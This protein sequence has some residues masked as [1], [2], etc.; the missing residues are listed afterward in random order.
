MA[1]QRRGIA[2]PTD[3]FGAI[4]SLVFWGG[5]LAAGGYGVFWIIGSINQKA[6]SEMVK[7]APRA[8]EANR[9]EASAANRK[10]PP[11]FLERYARPELDRAAAQVNLFTLAKEAAR[12]REDSAAQMEFARSVASARQR[13]RE[14]AKNES[15][16]PE[17]L[18]GN[19][20]VIGIEDTD[21]ARMRPELA[22]RAIIRAIAKIPSGSYLKVPVRRAGEKRDVI[23]YFAASAG[24]GAN[25]G[26]S[27]IKISNELAL[28]VQK[29]ML[30]LTSEQVTDADRKEVERILGA[31]EAT[32]EEYAMLMRRLDIAVADSNVASTRRDSFATFIAKL[33][34]LLPKAQVP[35]AIVM[36]DGRRFAGKLLQDTP[37]A[38]SV[39][40]PVGDI[41]VAKEDVAQL[42]TADNL[43]TEFKSKF[44]AGQQYRDALLQLL[45][46]TQEMNMPVHRELVAFTILE[47]TPNEPFARNAAGYVQMD[48]QWV[49]KSCIAAGAPIP[50]HKAET[51]DEIRRE[52]ESMGFVLRGAHWFS[53]VPW[54]TGIDSLYHAGPLKLNLN[55][56]SVMDWHVADT[57][58]YRL[59]DKPKPLG[60]LDLKFVAPTGPAGLCTIAVEAPGEI[61]EC[62]VRASGEII[63]DKQGGRIECFLTAE[64]GRS[65][66][67]YDISKKADLIFH[68]VTMYTRGKTKFTVTARILTVMDKYHTYAR[69]LPSAKSTTQAFW[70]K[71]VVLKPAAEFDRLWAEAK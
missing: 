42:V 62:Q 3:G 66:V 55:G 29:R 64:G 67:L 69:Y 35:E 15:A 13:F 45:V 39:R 36:K 23:L 4:W 12:I 59:D 58:I 70:V 49:L 20:E 9:R 7:N 56:T 6:N 46:W 38:V 30:L 8:L 1:I 57:P 40:T 27:M 63:E 28:E 37:A 19:D 25:A 60:P 43:R 5:L 47:A 26:P 53:K 52:L 24:L 71:G 14:L 11:A 50:E 65:E 31:G 10:P 61:I 68:D 44:I 33:N 2:N 32:D 34:A 51:K 22:S 17:L 41:T 16:V 54:S 48:G 18:E 21:F